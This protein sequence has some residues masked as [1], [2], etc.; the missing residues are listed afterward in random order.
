MK[1]K[2]H[3][4]K[5]ISS[6]IS[7][8]IIIIVLSLVLA[9]M[10]INSLYSKFNKVILP[11]AIS[12]TKKYMVEIINDATGNIKF[13]NNLFEIEKGDNNEIQM[14]NY[15]SYEATSLINNITYNIQDKLNNDLNNNKYIVAKI[16]LG[17]IFKNSL[18]RN[19][20]P[21]I[22]VK[23]KVV[24]NVLSEL[25]TEVKPYG[26]NNAVVS[27]RV[28]LKAQAEV[29]LPIVSKEIEI[30]NIIPISINIVNGSIPEAYISSYKN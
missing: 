4:K 30:E 29:I 5:T 25:E 19:F 11:M 20:G 15:N 9:I 10:V 1:L 16:P 6:H 21:M 2:Y 18:V 17:I 8:E 23:M 3:K 24:G 13:N 14:I 12:L 7:R 26:I 22:D 27:V 28:K